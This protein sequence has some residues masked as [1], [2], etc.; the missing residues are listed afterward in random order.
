MGT[1]KVSIEINHDYYQY[2]WKQSKEQTASSFSGL[3]F[4]HYKAAA[5]SD[6]LSKIHALKLA[7]IIKMGLAPERWTRGLSVMFEKWQA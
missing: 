6:T 4:G 7:L 1:D 5:Y 2:Y 3:H